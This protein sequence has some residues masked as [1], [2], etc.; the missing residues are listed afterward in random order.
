[1]G[2]MGVDEADRLGRADT[3]EMLDG[4]LPPQFARHKSVRTVEIGLMGWMG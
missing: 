1:M 3:L 2:E 4:V